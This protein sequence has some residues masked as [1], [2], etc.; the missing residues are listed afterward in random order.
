MEQGL[1]YQ[2]IHNSEALRAQGLRALSFCSINGKRRAVQSNQQVPS[3]TGEYFVVVKK[4]DPNQ[5]T[6]ETWG[7]K[8]NEQNPPPKD[9]SNVFNCPQ[10]WWDKLAN[11]YPYEKPRR[12]MRKFVHYFARPGQ[13]V[14][15]GFAGTI[16]CGLA[17]LTCG[18]N[19]VSV[20]N[21]EDTK[22]YLQVLYRELMA[23]IHAIEELDEEWSN[24][25]GSEA[26][27][28]V[29]KNTHFPNAPTYTLFAPEEFHEG[30]PVVDT[31]R[32]AFTHPN[33]PVGLRAPNFQ[34]NQPPIPPVVRQELPR[35]PV[36]TVQT[37]LVEGL[38]QASGGEES[39]ILQ[40]PQT[41]VFP[42]EV[43]EEEEVLTQITP[44]KQTLKRGREDSDS[45]D[46]GSANSF[47]GESQS[48]AY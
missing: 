28:F 32:S 34:G 22:R 24:Y 1:E 4:G 7:R 40:T 10:A 18:I 16:S 3:T 5:A 35:P 26:S 33:P 47:D 38:G 44:Q 19:L 20:D 14:F 12:L 21:N 42:A 17:A 36:L 13:L 11:R 37:A 8:Y 31:E 25:E 27:L 23:G 39:E 45:D 43:V 48:Q 6:F 46:N 41:P 9:L 30:I 29:A 2:K 15:E